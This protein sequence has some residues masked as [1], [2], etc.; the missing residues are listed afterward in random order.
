MSRDRKPDQ[1]SRETNS[2][3]LVTEV[4]AAIAEP[5]SQSPVA[6]PKSQGQRFADNVGHMERTTVPEPFGIATD[7]LAGVRLFEDMQESQM[8]IK[9]GEGRPED[10][11][12]QAVIDKLKGAGY[13]WNPAERIWT[14]PVMPH[15]AAT[16]RIAAEKLYQDVRQIV[17]QDKGIA[18][19]SPDIAF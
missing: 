14:F 6:E 16:T 1:S 4:G 9:F 15:S 19:V 10:K 18:P 13:R 8:V 7:K 5:P 11:P 12:S 2:E 17:R 3:R